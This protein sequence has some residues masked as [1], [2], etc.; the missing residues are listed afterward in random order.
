MRRSD[1]TAMP[2]EGFVNA[3]AQ[4]LEL[5]AVERQSLLEQPDPSPALARSSTCWILLMPAQR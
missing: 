3:L 4:H 2:D 5:G 1:Y